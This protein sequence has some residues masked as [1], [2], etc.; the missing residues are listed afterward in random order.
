MSK[1]KDLHQYLATKSIT[2]EYTD[3]KLVIKAVVSSQI[4]DR[5]GEIVDLNDVSLK[6]VGDTLAIPV[7][8]DHERYNSVDATVGSVKNAYI[9]NQELIFEMEFSNK[10][11]DAIEAFYL[12]ADGHLVNPFSIGFSYKDFNGV[13]YS[14]IEIFEVSV[15]AFP[16]NQMSRVLEVVSKSTNKE[17]ASIVVKALEVVNGDESNEQGT[18]ETI[19]E[20]E[21]SKETE[22]GKQT[23]E[24]SSEEENS[25]EI[26]EE[27]EHKMTP[28]EVQTAIE[29]AS[30]EAAAEATR[31]TLEALEAKKQEEAA[32]S[33]VKEQE[34]AVITAI[35]DSKEA[36]TIKSMRA[37][38]ERN[39]DLLS[40]MNEDA[41]KAFGLT[42]KAVHDYTDLGQAILCEELDRDITRCLDTAEGTIGSFV[43]RYNL[44]TSNKYSFVKLSGELNY[45]D[46]DN[47]E[48]KPSAGQLTAAKLSKEPRE[49]AGQLA[50]C[51][52]LADDM[53]VDIYSTIRD[54]FARAEN[55]LI[56]NLVF[57]FT[58]G[59][60]PTI[61]T[62]ILATAGVPTLTAT[63]ANRKQVLRGAVMALC[64]GARPGAIWAMNE[65]TWYECVLPL[66]DCDQSCSRELSQTGNF[67]NFIMTL[68]ER[69]IVI[70]NT[71]PAGVI[72]LGDFR[73]F[74]KYVTKGVRA[75]D[76][77]DVAKSDVLN[78]NAW[79]KDMTLV[80]SY[81]R[82]TGVVKDETAFVVITCA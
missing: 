57:N 58:G 7:I 8:L 51:D 61:A 52:N 47:C 76:F 36:F 75:I 14:G 63:A 43:G 17:L 45:V 23:S 40:K 67:G 50:V 13:V 16:A 11:E 60:D 5:D 22:L 3:N 74:F 26:K 70:D 55:R 56:G 30:R 9:E 46:I 32:N 73:N 6:K 59:G 24:L 66:L 4:L 79:D 42:T 31:T 37:A 29:K 48:N 19:R 39:I 10:K 71:I 38:K 27:K 33:Q 62:G 1:N 25:N 53:M 20:E 78:V 34:E 69:P 81:L 72:I 15:T 82:A 12:I 77:S 49:W 28:E 41:A 65:Q 44:T 2:S 18:E 35:K 64:A 80:R 68:W 54:E 21:S